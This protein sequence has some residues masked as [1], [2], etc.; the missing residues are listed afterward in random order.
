MPLFSATDL[1]RWAGGE[2]TSRPP[3]RIGGVCHDTRKLK[4]DDLYLALAGERHDGHAFVSDAFA[5]GACGA[6][7]RTAAAPSLA[8]AVPNRPL[9]RVDDPAEAMRRMASA[10]RRAV[11][12]TAIAVTGTAGKS[13]VKEVTGQVL[14]R[15]VPTARTRGNWNNEIGLPL[16]LLAMEPGTRFGVFELGMNH[17]GEIR[18]L[19]RILQPDWTVVTNIGPG[20]IEFFPDERAIADEKADALRALPPGGRAFLW[21]ETRFADLLRQACGCP[22]TWVSAEGPADYTCAA[23]RR[24]AGAFVVREAATGEDAELR[25]RLPGRHDLVNALFA[26]AVGRAA[27]MSWDAIR[28]GL[29]NFQP[30]PMRSETLTVNGLRIVNDAYNANP[31]SMRAAV[32]AFGATP[33]PGARWLVLGDMLELGERTE[34][35]HRLLGEFV[36]RGDWAGLVL[37]GDQARRVAEAAV[38]AGYAASRVVVCADKNAAVAALKAGARE[39]DALLFKG[40]RGMK[41]EEI[42]ERFTQADKGGGP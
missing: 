4:P 31:L 21:K 40:S 25:W 30:M 11:A 12:P 16:S 6:V 37:L 23:W 1:A 33:V 9:L 27:G 19:C 42:V 20:H 3:Q 2:W 32:E 35:E 26:V 17:P 8:A 41:L 24:A 5:R 10:Y 38:A 14:E 18:G 22:V 34:T 13:T 36:G 39:G 7:V 15:H 29:D 28:P